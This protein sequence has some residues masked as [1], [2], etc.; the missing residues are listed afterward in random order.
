MIYLNVVFS[1]PHLQPMFRGFFAR[2]FCQQFASNTCCILHHLPRPPY[3]EWYH[4]LVK[5]TLTAGERAGGPE[6]P[7]LCEASYVCS[8]K[9][10]ERSSGFAPYGTSMAATTCRNVAAG[11]SCDCK[12]NQPAPLLLHPFMLY[13]IPWEQAREVLQKLRILGFLGPSPAVNVFLTNLCYHSPRVGG[14]GGGEYNTYLI[15]I[16]LKF[17]GKKGLRMQAQTIDNLKKAWHYYGASVGPRVNVAESLP[18]GGSNVV[19]SLPHLQPMFLGFFARG[20][21]QQFVSNTCCIL[22]H[23]PRPPYGEWYHK[24]VKETLTAGERAG[25]PESP[26]LCEASYVCS[27]KV[28]GRSSGFAPYGTSMA[29]TT[30]R[31]IRIAVRIPLQATLRTLQTPGTPSCRRFIESAIL[32]CVKYRMM[33]GRIATVPLSFPLLV[34]RRY[35]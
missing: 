12:T 7:G 11:L 17:I 6:S 8:Y 32:L 1:P 5:E 31:N 20:F 16:W 14:G 26:G 27:Y 4:K 30:C 19:F 9:V 22:Y 25:G 18:L 10:R 33:V 35:R 21:C 13:L 15:Q 28:R 29:F 3:G 24:L 34:L 23:L 2:D